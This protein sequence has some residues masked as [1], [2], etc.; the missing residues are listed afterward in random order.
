MNYDLFISYRRENGSQMARLLR[1]YLE[2]RGYRVFL[3]VEE[4]KAGHFD[5][6]LLR[7]IEAAQ[8]FIVILSPGCLDRCKNDGDWL[9]IEIAQALKLGKK[10]IPLM[11]EGFKFPPKTEMPEDMNEL[12][13]HQAVL[14]SNDFFQASMD[15]LC[16][17][18]GS[19]KGIKPPKTWKS[20][21][22]LGGGLALLGGAIAYLFLH[23]PGGTVNRTGENTQA[24]PTT[25]SGV[26]QAPQNALP[27]LANKPDAQMV[28]IPAGTFMMG[29]TDGVGATDE[30][31]Q[32]EVYLDAFYIDKYPVTF[33]EFD[34]FCEATGAPKPA[35]NGWGRAA[36]PVVN[37][38]WNDAQAYAKWAGK[39]LPTE[40]E[41]E[42]AVRGGTNTL[43]FFGYDAAQL[44]DY[45]WDFDN[46]GGITHRVGQ[47]KP[48]P[49]GLY[50][51]IGNVWEWCSDWYGMDYYSMSPPKNP[52]GPETGKYR[53]LRGGSLV[54]T[55]MNLRSAMR[56]WGMPES[57]TPRHGFRCAKDAGR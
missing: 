12:D 33:D 26:P 27:N 21:V 34:K 6:A 23:H 11:M 25:A 2:E 20:L 42:K 51:I 48:N 38:S 15:K 4:L 5:M 54:D 55:P 44:G 49:F 32:H 24:Q 13:R 57:R 3:D 50:D 9:R 22:L 56:D 17:N 30:H 52:Q 37:V 43:Y 41:Y 35:D 40:A 8:T 53:V 14:Y 28:L 19:P 47:K 7:N 10:I 29:S 45:A 39:R 16:G 1:T 36:R 46:A 31:I 18:L